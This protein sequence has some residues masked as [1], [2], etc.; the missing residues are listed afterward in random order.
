MKKILIILLILLFAP[1]A[2]SAQQVEE[3]YN[4]LVNSDELYFQSAVIPDVDVKTEGKD[5]GIKTKEGRY[6]KHMPFFKET[7]LKIKKALK[8]HYLRDEE[9]QKLREQKWAEEDIQKQKKEVDDLG[10]KYL[11]YNDDE[12]K[13][14]TSDNKPKS[15]KTAE[16]KEQ[17]SA[18]N[19]QELEGVVKEQVTSTEFQ[20]DC[21]EVRTDEETGDV[22]AIG[23]PILT[24]VPQNITVKADKMIYNRN[25]NILKAFD[26]VV[27]TKDGMPIMGD[28]IQINMNEE[29]MFMDNVRADS[30]TM[31]ITA[32]K[33]VSEE[34][35][36]ILE[37]GHS[38]SEHSNKFVFASRMVGPD[39]TQMII[40]DKDKYNWISGDDAK[41]RI[42]ASE[43]NIH[44]TDNNDRFQ[45]K[46]AEFFYKDKYIMTLPSLTAYTNKNRDYFEANYLN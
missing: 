42:N 32:R 22:E 34:G 1:C 7:R 46:D 28:Y 4:D 30:P 39:F 41:M 16:V 15:D 27:V 43:I 35:K 23:N 13:A 24:Y 21:D 31:T 25:S 18:E 6:D 10:I 9:K 19:I 44:A 20:L 2:H 26:N 33:A 3:I 29:N 36:L 38:N 14:E 8:S 45:V 17:P 5:E 11:E 40:D 37:K 12:E